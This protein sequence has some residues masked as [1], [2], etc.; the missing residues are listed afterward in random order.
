MLRNCKLLGIHCT[1][2]SSDDHEKKDRVFIIFSA[3]RV[4]PLL[5]WLFAGRWSD[6]HKGFKALTTRGRVERIKQQ[7]VAGKIANCVHAVQ[8]N[9]RKRNCKKKKNLKSIEKYHNESV[10]SRVSRVSKSVSQLV[11]Q[12]VIHNK[13]MWVGRSTSWA[14]LTNTPIGQKL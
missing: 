2:A 11:S 5:N 8:K 13:W 12:W 9:Y 4:L 1:G 10:V 7:G 6:G 14:G 3:A